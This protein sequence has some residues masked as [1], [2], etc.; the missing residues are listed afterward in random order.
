MWQAEDATAESGYI[1][2]TP[3]S[4]SDSS[5]GEFG[6]IVWSATGEIALL[7]FTIPSEKVT[8]ANGNNFKVFAR[9]ANVFVYEDLYFKAILRI[10]NTTTTITE[11]AWTLLSKDT[12][13]QDIGTIKIPPFNIPNSLYGW[14]DLELVLV[15]SKAGAGDY[16]V[17]LD[18]LFLAPVDLHRRLRAVYPLPYGWYV[19]DNSYKKVGNQVGV[20]YSIDMTNEGDIITHTGIGPPIL[21]YPGKT[22]QLFFA[23]DGMS[24]ECPPIGATLS[25]TMWY[26]P[27]RLT[28]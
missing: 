13:L 19:S 16:T 18:Y 20:V 22:N 21:L 7:V 12:G 8:D 25:V 1:A 2:L 28:L 11:S 24:G 14:S 27:R 9:F 6:R 26:Y 5:A 17:D 10:Q 4:D 23:F 3:T 15:A